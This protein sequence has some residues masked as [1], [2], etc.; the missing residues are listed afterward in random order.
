MQEMIVGEP[1]KWKPGTT[2]KGTPPKPIAV[3]AIDFA[4]DG[5]FVAAFSDDHARIFDGVN[6][7]FG[8]GLGDAFYDRR[9]KP[10]WTTD[11]IVSG[12][13]FVPGSERVATSHFDGNLRIWKNRSL[14]ETIPLGAE[15]PPAPPPA[16]DW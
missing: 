7:K 8:W 13:C 6:D 2:W 4:P 16:V 15:Q 14:E 3:N 5:K 12:A 9:P 11:F 10:E 1:K